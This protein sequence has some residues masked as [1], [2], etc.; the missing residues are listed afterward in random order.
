M[1]RSPKKRS[2]KR[3][4]ISVSGPCWG[5][6]NS[7]GPVTVSGAAVRSTVTLTTAG[8]TFSTRSA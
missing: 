8:M 2:M 3:W 1:P 5:P 6:P 7:R 4:N